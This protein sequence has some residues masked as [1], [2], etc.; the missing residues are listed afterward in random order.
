MKVVCITLDI[1][2]KTSVT[3]K[4]F[5]MKFLWKI[6]LL[7][8]VHQSLRF[9]PK[10][11]QPGVRQWKKFH[12]KQRYKSI[13]WFGSKEFFQRVQFCT[14]FKEMSLGRRSTNFHPTTRHFAKVWEEASNLWKLKNPKGFLRWEGPAS[15]W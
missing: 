15:K 7:K 13:L 2:G 10:S 14:F 9:M 8:T 11:I 3:E 6:C 5:R 4:S 12:R 1:M